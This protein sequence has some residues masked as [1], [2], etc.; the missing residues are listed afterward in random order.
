LRVI[1][2]ALLKKSAEQ[3]RKLAENRSRLHSISARV[4]RI[5]REPERRKPPRKKDS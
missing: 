3:R 2:T 5:E 1:A 4:A